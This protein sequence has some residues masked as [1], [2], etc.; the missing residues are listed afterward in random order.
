MADI[1]STRHDAADVADIRA[2]LL[3]VYAEVY[4]ADLDR[5]FH[6]V[7]TFAERLDAYATSPGFACV[8]GWEGD[9]P[10]GYAFGYALRPGARW[11][12]GLTEDVPDTVTTETGTRTFALNELMVRARWRGTGAARAIHDALVADR[13]EPRVTLLVDPTHPAVVA[14]Y[15]RWG[16]HVLSP[17]R[18]AWSGAPLFLAMLWERERRPDRIDPP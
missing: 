3:D 18:P 12:I 6:S 7:A 2:S 16:Y 15:E 14:L 1:A 9:V 8:V 11:W 13:P 4:A 10:V 5:P 17:L